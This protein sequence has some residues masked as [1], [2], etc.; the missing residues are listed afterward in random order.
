MIEF[1]LGQSLIQV[2]P[3]ARYLHTVYRDGAIVRAAPEDN[4][5][6]REMAAR[7]GYGGDTWR[8]CLEHEVFHTLMAMAAGRVVSPAL[9]IVAHGSEAEYNSDLVIR[10]EEA[11]LE[12]QRKYNECFR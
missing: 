9:W 12:F 4:D 3:D 1:T 2:W 7:L 11:V 8:M 10:E 5:S 6:Y